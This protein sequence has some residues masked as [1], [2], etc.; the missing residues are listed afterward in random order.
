MKN[1]P[2]YVLTQFEPSGEG[3]WDYTL[4]TPGGVVRGTGF[5][6]REQVVENI[7]RQMEKADR[8]SRGVLKID[9]V[10]NGLAAGDAAA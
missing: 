9:D 6:T 5:G 2:L 10:M 4:M 1:N 8:R 3:R 7:R